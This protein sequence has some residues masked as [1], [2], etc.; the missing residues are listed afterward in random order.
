MHTL[1]CRFSEVVGIFMKQPMASVI[2]S[3]W[4]DF[5]RCLGIPPQIIDKSRSDVLLD[6]LSINDIIEKLLIEW[7]SRSG[8]KGTIEALLNIVDDN[9]KWQSVT[10]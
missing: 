3:E 1:G 9:F 5:A 8:N 4:T 6:K 2:K 10:G 7:R